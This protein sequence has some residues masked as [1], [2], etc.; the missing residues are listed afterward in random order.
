MARRRLITSVGLTIKRPEV[1]GKLIIDTTHLYGSGTGS[2]ELNIRFYDNG[3]C[4]LSHDY[5]TSIGYGTSCG[6]YKSTNETKE[7]VSYLVLLGSQIEVRE[8][9]LSE[10]KES[11]DQLVQKISSIQE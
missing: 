1:V 4:T 11:L 9:K 8:S 3:N 10:L 6:C 2:S 7:T 5:E